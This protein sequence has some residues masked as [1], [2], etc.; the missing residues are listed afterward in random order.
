MK[1]IPALCLVLSLSASVV[2]GQQGDSPAG[3]KQNMPM[4]KQVSSLEGDKFEIRFLQMMIAHHEAGIEMAQLVQDRAQSNELKK[5]ANEMIQKEREDI[6]K[7]SAWLKGWHN[8]GPDGK[9]MPQHGQ[10]MQKEIEKLRG[11]ENQAFD[12]AFVDTMTRHHQ[13]GIAMFETVE[14]RTQREPL[15]TFATENIKH[16]RQ[17]IAKL[18]KIG[19]N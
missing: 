1:T 10:M 12:Q 2:F 8:E 6:Q 4:L 11:L 18:Q 15:E 16:Q 5:L 9:A 19:G 17:E 3:E 7:M 14:R 13:G